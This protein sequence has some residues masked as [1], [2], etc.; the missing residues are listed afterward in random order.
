MRRMVKA[1]RAVK[2]DPKDP[3]HADL[4]DDYLADAARISTPIMFVTGDRNRVFTDSNVV[5]H[6][7]LSELAP[8]LHELEVLP[9][10]GHQD[11]IM[12]KNA[13]RDVFPQMIAFLKK[14]SLHRAPGGTR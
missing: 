13:F 7:I 8:G 14:H 10:Y 4:P 11:P 9:G 12:G 2:Y 5:S 3:R 1:G 6:K